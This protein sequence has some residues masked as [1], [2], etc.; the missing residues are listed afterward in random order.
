MTGQ[1]N[2]THLPAPLQRVVIMGTG[3]F[4]LEAMEAAGR[5][6]AEHITLVS[7]PRQRWVYRHVLLLVPCRLPPAA[8]RLPPAAAA[9]GVLYACL[10]LPLAPC[11]LPCLPAVIVQSDKFY[12][13]CPPAPALTARPACPAHCLQVGAALLPPVHH[14]RVELHAPGAVAHQ[15]Q[16]RHGGWAHAAHAAHTVLVAPAAPAALAHQGHA[17]H[18]G[19]TL[20]TVRTLPTLRTLW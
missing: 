9:A 1:P 5:S 10:A 13:D 11:C 16:A 14:Q 2:P 15:D 12:Q 3:S 18:T 17:R 19:P 20:R 7:R 6:G 8:C 4:A